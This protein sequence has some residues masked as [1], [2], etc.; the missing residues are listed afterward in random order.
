[1][2]VANLLAV[3]LADS[4]TLHA[5]TNFSTQGEFPTARWRVL[6]T[7]PFSGY[8]HRNNYKLNVSMLVRITDLVSNIVEQVPHFSSIRHDNYQRC[9]D[10]FYL[11][12]WHRA[13]MAVANLLAVRLADGVTLHAST[14]F[15][16]GRVSNSSVASIAHYTL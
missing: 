14:S 7:I 6:L 10:T 13:F 11:V 9:T 16:P 1:M 12:I 15:Y 4:V 5:S 2:A 3:R 8:K